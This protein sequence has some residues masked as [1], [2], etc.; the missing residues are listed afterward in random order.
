MTARFDES[1]KT[2]Q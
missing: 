1:S 2:C